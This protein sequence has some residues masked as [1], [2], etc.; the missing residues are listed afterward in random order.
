[1]G[2]LSFFIS[3]SRDNGIGALMAKR[4]KNKTLSYVKHLVLL[5]NCIY[6]FCQY[7]SCV[8]EIEADPV[9]WTG[10]VFSDSVII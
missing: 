7:G 4:K 3:I 10:Q 2:T 5:K 8:L 6:W 1:M 9:H